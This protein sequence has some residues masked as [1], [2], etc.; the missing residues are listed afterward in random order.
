MVNNFFPQGI[1]HR[2]VN[3]KFC[4]IGRRNESLTVASGSHQRL[5]TFL[6]HGLIAPVHQLVE[7][8]FA[9]NRVGLAQQRICAQ[10]ARQHRLLRVSAHRSRD[11]IRQHERGRGT[12]SRQTESARRWPA[13]LG[14]HKGWSGYRTECPALRSTPSRAIES[15]RSNSDSDSADRP[16]GGACA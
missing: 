15:H 3:Q 14:I 8:R 11:P 2:F 6:R 12:S 1:A 7:I 13:L 5:Q 10:Q 16:Q 9:I 4:F